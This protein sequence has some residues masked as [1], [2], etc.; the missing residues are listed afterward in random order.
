MEGSV[1]G[2]E[3]EA[4]DPFVGFREKKNFIFFVY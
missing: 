4:V 3:V 1:S 2:G